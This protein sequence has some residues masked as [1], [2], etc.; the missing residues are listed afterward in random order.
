MTKKISRITTQKKSKSRYNI[1][2]AD[3]DQDVYAFSVD[4]AVLIEYG[5]RKGLELDQSMIETLEKKDTI[6][7]AY[8][9]AINFLSY[10][11]RTKK[12]LHDYLVKKEV[13]PE[14]S[15]IILEKLTDEGYVNDKEF[16]T[17]FVQTRINTSTKGP[18]LVK[19]ELIEKGVTQLIATEAITQYTY[20]IQYEKA[21]K[22]VDKKL[23]SSKKDSFRKQVQQLQSN[24][25]QKGFTQDVVQDVTQSMQEEKNDDEEWDAL[26]YQGEK[27]IRKFEKKHSGFAFRNKVKEGLFR[28]GFSME[29]IN[30]FVEEKIVE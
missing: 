28:K 21:E 10:R 6:Q 15:S 12:E 17:A 20:G 3:G 30:K 7:K 16:A 29:N 5:L 1:Y 14:H 8:S 9:L 11:M 13:E 2:L 19:K 25:I 18:L 26:V 24:L 22:W 27:L 4:E 23:R